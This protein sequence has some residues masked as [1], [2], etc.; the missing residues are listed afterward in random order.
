M[1]QLVKD[2]NTYIQTRDK[3]LL[4]YILTSKEIKNM[5]VQITLQRK[6]QNQFEVP[7]ADDLINTLYLLLSQYQGYRIFEN[8]NHLLAFLRQV[9]NTEINFRFRK[10]KKYQ[11]EVLVDFENYNMNA[12]EDIY[13]K[14]DFPEYIQQLFKQYPYLYKHLIEQYSI[15]EL[16]REYGITPTAMHYRIEN[17]KD[18]IRSYYN[19]QI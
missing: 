11:Q 19:S 18:K 16:A 1:D 12:T 3:E 8:K 17:K 2:F 5:I 4:A 9:I 15:S 10:Y 13:F 7:E 6:R 14:D